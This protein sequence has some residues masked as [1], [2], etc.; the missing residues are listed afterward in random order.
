MRSSDTESRKH[1]PRGPP[2]VA[3]VYS[4]QRQLARGRRGHNPQQLTPR[5]R[6]A[7]RQKLPAQR[8]RWRR[9]PAATKDTVSRP[10]V[11]ER[12]DSHISGHSRNAA[13][14]RPQKST[15]EPL[16]WRS[17]PGLLSGGDNPLYS[18]CFSGS[19][20]VPLCVPAG[21]SV[22]SGPDGGRGFTVTTK[23]KVETSP[24][25]PR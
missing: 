6:V 15:K 7:R 12:P 13:A 1:I 18:R 11:T 4:Y 14:R 23:P 20:C 24:T 22:T 21:R 25:T 10:E 19:A 5:P 9:R 17:R 2:R 8:P 3:T 16:E